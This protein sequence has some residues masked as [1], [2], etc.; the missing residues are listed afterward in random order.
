MEF[1]HQATKNMINIGLKIIYLTMLLSLATF[2]VRGLTKIEKRAEL[3]N[4]LKRYAIDI[5][6][7]Q[8][9]NCKES[10]EVITDVGSK[11]IVAA[12]SNSHHRGVGFLI[13]KKFV[14][15]VTGW[16]QLSDDVI[17][18]YLS[19]PTNSGK[20]INTRIVNCYSPTF[21]S[22]EKNPELLESFYDVVNK[23]INIP[24]RF[25]LYVLGDFNAVIDKKC[26]VDI[27]NIGSYIH[28]NNFNE[29]G[30]QLLNFVINNSLFICNTAFTHKT[31]H[32]TTHVQWV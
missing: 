8:E 24:Q 1:D 26:S 19:I 21:V 17:C 28:G 30:R 32:I 16:K 5:I 18:V 9:T 4:D 22:V 10:A 13:S 15:F 23:A 14:E 6:A 29:N 2:N 31:S 3:E 20:V 27:D 11:L 7:I 25:D 12:Q